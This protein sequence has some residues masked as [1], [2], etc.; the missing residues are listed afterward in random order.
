M[1]TK[2][3]ARATADLALLMRLTVAF[4]A[5]TEGALK[6]IDPARFGAGRFARLGLPRPDFL[7][8]FVGGTELL[9]AALLLVGLWARPACV[10]LIVIKLVALARVKVPLMASQGFWFGAYEAR[11]DVAML[12]VATAVLFTGAGGWSLDSWLRQRRG[13]R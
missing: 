2:K 1:E 12:L 10:P 11:V 3:P 4:L 7:G 9:C 6:Y 5:C 13:K 8:P